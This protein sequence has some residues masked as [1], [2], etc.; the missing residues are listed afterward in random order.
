M[1]SRIQLNPIARV[2]LLALLSLALAFPG[3]VGAKDLP[4]VEGF[5]P[6]QGPY[7][8]QWGSLSRFAIPKWFQDAKLGIFLHWGPYAV[9]AFGNE[10]YPRNMYR[11]GSR[12]FNHHRETYGPQDE[13]GYKDFIGRFAAEKWDPEAWA[14]LFEASGAR[15]VVPVGEHHD[16]FP[17]YECSYTE[18]NAARMGP[19]RDI[20]GELFEACRARGLKV[21]VSS[22]RAF[23]WEYYARNPEFD[24]VDPAY[25]GLYGT[26]PTQPWPDKPF[27][28]N[29]LLRT[30]ELARKY[31]PDIVWFDFYFGN[32]EF[33]P[34]RRLFAADYYNHGKRWGQD[35]LIQYKYD[36][37]PEGA[38][39]LDIER[40]KLGDIRWRFWQTDTSVD[41]RSWCYIATPEYKPANLIVDDLIDIVSKNG[42]LLLNIGPRPD[43]TIP[44]G[45][46]H[47]LQE[48]GQWLKVN[49][50]AIYGTRPWVRYGEGPTR[51]A[52]GAHQERKNKGGTAQDFRFTRKGDVL[53]AI[54]LDWPEEAFIVHSLGRDVTAK[55]GLS[56][57][58]VRFLGHDGP[59][60]WTQEADALHVDLP[61]RRPGKHAYT[62]KISIDGLARQVAAFK[63]TLP[64]DKTIYCEPAMCTRHGDGFRV[65]DGRID[66]WRSLDAVS[67]D[68]RIDEPGTYEIM[69]VQAFAGEPGRYAVTI[70]GQE[71]TATVVDTGKWNQYEAVPVGRVRLATTDTYTLKM[72]PFAEPK[73]NSVNL[74]RLE[75]RRVGE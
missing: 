4:V 13:F 69:A 31:R 1:A 14:A 63:K 38:G 6:V 73:W 46:Q 8:P 41:F 22:H 35:V 64:P 30:V 24:T 23:N 55:A 61:A 40:G 36:A 9:P 34:Y 33:E 67:W 2:G 70:A 37:L 52:G 5:T 19:K 60:S 74:E 18:W 11:E 32:P 27:L 45:Q 48:L 51:T 62:L 16:G 59:V 71:L 7:R 10:W 44:E 50:E 66:D 49:G 25:F 29:W 54:C 3:H 26:P 57:R 28:N 53:Y 15:Y 21:G 72:Q 47:I 75:L 43:G 20:V 68:V 12:V 39:V 42:S 65:R 58:D 56:I 17:M